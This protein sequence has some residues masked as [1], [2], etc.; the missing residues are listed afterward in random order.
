MLSKSKYDT[1]WHDYHE[2]IAPKGLEAFACRL[3]V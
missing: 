2:V 3:Y 1:N